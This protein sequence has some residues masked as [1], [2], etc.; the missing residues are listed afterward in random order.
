MTDFGH[1]IGVPPQDGSQQP[2]GQRQVYQ[3]FGHDLPEPPAEDEPDF[4]TDR[5][6]ARGRAEA[7]DLN[8]ARTVIE[9]AL[10]AGELQLGHD[11]PGLV[12]LMVDLATYARR[13]GNLTEAR[14]QL[15]RAHTLS[16][17]ASGLEHPTSLA[18]Q[19]RLAAVE[20]R[21]GEPTA[22]ADQHLVDT[23][24]RVLGAEHPAVR[25]AAQRLAHAGD[26]A[27][28]TPSITRASTAPSTTAPGVAAPTAAMP[29][30][31]PDPLPPP[32]E[33]DIW[34][35]TPEEPTVRVRRAGRG[36]L[37][38]VAA[39]G[40]VVL[41]GAV[42]AALQLFEPGGGPSAPDPVTGQGG[43]TTPAAVLTSPAPYAL[44]VADDGGTVILTWVDPSGGQVPFVVSGAR[45]GNAPLA[46]Q[47]VPAGQTRVT[48]YGL[49]VNYDY[50]FT[51]A[52][53]WSSDLVRES[54]RTCTHRT[55]PGAH[56]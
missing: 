16:V 4:A 51:V 25:G 5:T 47:S 26:L 29:V 43:T 54:I 48:I 14:N 46:I 1:S 55:A 44:T 3:P 8:G 53:V 18:V 45:E 36:G 39:L 10:A 20:S 9:E 22:A 32:L 11:D 30:V 34:V 27:P 42:V 49:N 33:G 37:A 31:A 2:Y 56:G 50:C 28:A 23:G 17:A 19:G 35:P 52:A 6:L 41:V 40:A 7:G 38:L 21:L 24:A 15:R 12:P 13:L